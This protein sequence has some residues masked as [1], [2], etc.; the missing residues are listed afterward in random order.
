MMI[1]DVL[2]ANGKIYSKQKRTWRFD[3]DVNH[4]EVS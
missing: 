2:Y 4:P 3:T 1:Y